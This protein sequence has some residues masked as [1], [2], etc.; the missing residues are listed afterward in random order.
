M[1]KGI[2]KISIFLIV[3]ALLGLPTVIGAQGVCD[4]T[5]LSSVVDD[6]EGAS[7]QNKFLGYWFFYNDVDDGG[8]SVVNNSEPTD[9]GQLLFSGGYG[10]GRDGSEHA[11]VLDYTMGDTEPSCG[12]TCTFG[13]FVGVGT[14][15]HPEV[16]NGGMLDISTA[17]KLTMWMKASAPDMVVRVEVAT[18][19][20]TDHGMFRSEFPLT[21]EWALY[22]IDFSDVLNFA[23]PTWAEPVEAFAKDMVQKI[24][25]QISMDYKTNP[26]EGI[27]YIDDVVIEDY[28][29]VPPNACTVVGAA[30]AGAGVDFS[31]MDVA[32]KN[33]NNVGGFW[34]AYNDAEG[35]TV[36]VGEFSDVFAGVVKDAV[37]PTLID[38]KIDGNG[39]N[40]TDGAYIE[41][42]LGP[43]YIENGETI[44]PFVGVGT[45]TSND[46]GTLVA[47]FETHGV[48]AVS[49]DYM[50][51]GNFDYGR[52]EMKADQGFENSGIIHHCM[53]PNSCG[54]W[55]SITVDLAS[56]LFLPPWDEVIAMPAFMKELNKA[57]ILG[58][59]WA[60]Q[61]DPGTTGKLSVDNV[62][63]VGPTS[64]DSTWLVGAER[65]PGNAP[66]SFNVVAGKKS[67]QIS[68][69]KFDD[70][71]VEIVNLQGKVLDVMPKEIVHGKTSVDISNLTRG[72]YFVRIQKV[73]GGEVLS[74]QQMF[75]R[76]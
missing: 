74:Q 25:W 70:A 11:A 12:A 67:L 17:T 63:L 61:G 56:S 7:N 23:Q 48:T 64:I 40:E 27:L 45:N 42:E 8:N 6:F 73:R 39:A 2:K 66:A 65:R 1:I 60:V 50:T 76:I 32:P 24:Q 4:G 46:L 54:A 68:N 72:V 58:M 14:G 52:F 29:W 75:T 19:D 15:L 47:D 9:D 36:G 13:Q 28:I 22:E 35:R 33:K 26:M 57:R 62:K 20:I 10:E 49:F 44:R 55:K 59:Q 69:I 30:G 16:D 53:I 21:T 41:F 37:E 71:K 43:T 34:Y 5:S 51:D 3:G 18:G 31:N 38:I